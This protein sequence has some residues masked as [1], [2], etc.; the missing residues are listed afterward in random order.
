[1]VE[2][3]FVST[4]I[5]K[6]DEL[7][8][9]GIQKGFTMLISTIPGSNIEIISKQMASMGD[10]IYITTD[11]TKE[12]IIST[13]QDFSWDF[14]KIEFEDIARK[15][16]N[17]VLEGESKRVSIYRQRSKQSIK[18][19]IKAGSEGIPAQVSSEDDYL[20]IM[21]SILRKYSDKK[22]II[23]NLDFFLSNYKA[24]DIIKILRAG[25]VNILDEN[26]VLIIIITRGIHGEAIERQIE[27]L[28]DCVLVLDI[29]QRGPDYERIISVKK[30]RNIAKKIGSARYDI[31]DKGFILEDV[32]RIL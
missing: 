2:K 16:L 17:Y 14:S 23:N 26:G 32:E 9:G 22:I 15:H 7:I 20:A 18:E 21:S 24:S 11:E 3:T 19:L 13:M 30:L 4:G 1:M 28:A 29:V 6:L 8:G 5:E 25:K 10:P 31:N 12:E 27:L